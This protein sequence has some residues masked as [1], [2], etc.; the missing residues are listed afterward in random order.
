[1]A[2]SKVKEA[3]L[4]N[5]VRGSL[6]KEA[7]FGLLIPWGEMLQGTISTHTSNIHIQTRGR[8]SHPSEPYLGEGFAKFPL[9]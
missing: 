9:V 5:L 1:M 6:C 8:L 3:G 2:H 4:A 7:V